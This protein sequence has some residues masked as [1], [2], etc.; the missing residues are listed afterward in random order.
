MTTIQ[1]DNK[2]KI[3]KQV[4]IKHL[5][6][7]LESFIDFGYFI[8]TETLFF[9][10]FNENMYLRLLQTCLVNILPDVDKWKGRGQLHI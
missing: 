2:L 4:F 1:H 7:I 8:M 10:F 5:T 3:K 9:Q 6:I